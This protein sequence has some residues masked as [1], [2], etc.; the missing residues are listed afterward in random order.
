MEHHGLVAILS[1]N[2]G[3]QLDTVCKQTTVE[4]KKTGSLSLSGGGYGGSFGDAQALYDAN[5]Y[6]EILGVWIREE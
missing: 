5:L 3:T 1:H 6:H 4:P 2:P